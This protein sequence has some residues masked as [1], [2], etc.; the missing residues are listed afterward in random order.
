M[1]DKFT[2]RDFFAYFLS[3]IA[4]L[5]FALVNS[6]DSTLKFL[7]ANKEIIKDFTALIIFFTIPIAYFLGQTL[8]GLDTLLFIFAKLTRKIKRNSFF[9][10]ALYPFTFALNGPRISGFLFLQKKDIETFWSNCA[11]LQ[12]EKS[13]AS[14]E[15]WYVM[16]DLFK[17]LSFGS[18]IFSFISFYSNTRLLAI[19]Y[20]LLSMI[21]WFRAYFFAKTFIESATRLSNQTP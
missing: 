3:G 16:N 17:G 8:H 7:V 15:Y 14:C 13:Y 1:N 6:Y 9:W 10:Y 20:L 5:L 18:L 19:C 12:V 4:I 21:F 2:I 11:K